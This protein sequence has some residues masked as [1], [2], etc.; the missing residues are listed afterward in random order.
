MGEPAKKREAQSVSNSHKD[1]I[2]I[3]KG[4]HTEEIVI[5]LCGQLG[6]DLKVIERLLVEELEKYN[7]LHQVIKL[8]DYFNLF[9]SKILSQIPN[10]YERIK[11]GMDIGNELREKYGNQFLAELA[12]KDI[13]KDRLRDTSPLDIEKENFR[14]RRKCYIIS[15][16]KHPDELRLLQE[17]YRDLLYVIGVFSPINMRVQ[18]LGIKMGKDKAKI[19]ELIDR[20]TGED[21]LY[22]QNVEATFVE[23][24][25]FLRIDSTGHDN[26]KPKIE[27]FLKLVFD[28]GIVT[29]HPDETAMY[30]AAAAAV[31]SACLSRQVGACITDEQ[32]SIL[33]LGWNDVPAFGGNLYPNIKDNIDG[34]CFNSRDCNCANKVR[35][36]KIINDIIDDLK[37]NSVITTDDQDFLLK[38]ILERNGIK[39][40]IEF[41]RSIHAEMHAIIIGSQ[42]TGSKMVGG[43][44]F[45]TTYPC[46]NCARHIIAAGIHNVYYIEP[47]KKSLC[48]ELH[49]DAITEDENEKDKVKILM[50]EGVAPKRYMQVY[51]LTTDNRKNKI[52]H[53]NLRMV[54][55]KNTVTLRALHQLEAAVTKNLLE[56]GIN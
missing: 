42:K 17:I 6:T 45:C 54:K 27:H 30:Q 47:Y 21:K 19:Y 28:V 16:L 38:S 7:Y 14:S 33:A 26:I 10:E 15:S 2:E 12:I 56:K 55:P 53:Q 32:G 9:S 11:T 46:H 52:G 29:P 40:L 34:R 8:S 1:S 5:A 13:I 43:K 4:T 50:Y 22:G 18:Q 36:D 48:T 25:Y 51:K 31:N 39:N 3:L 44:L 20:D 41:A 24:D 49:Y 37:K 35:K 23:A